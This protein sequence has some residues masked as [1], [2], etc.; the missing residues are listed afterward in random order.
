MTVPLEVQR[1]KSCAQEQGQ[2][3]ATGEPPPHGERSQ[4]VAPK[5]QGDGGVQRRGINEFP[6]HRA[7]PRADR[8]RLRMLIRALNRPEVWQTLLKQSA[9][10]LEKGMP[11]GGLEPH[12]RS[13]WYLNQRVYQFRQVGDCWIYGAPQNGSIASRS[14]LAT[15]SGDLCLLFGLGLLLLPLLAVELSRPGICV[16]ELSSCCSA[17]CW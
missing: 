6:R 15:L 3:P 16:W 5:E 2:G 14:M 11:T 10:K 17:W 8:D 13:H 4:G 9:T 12:D 1:Q 7:I